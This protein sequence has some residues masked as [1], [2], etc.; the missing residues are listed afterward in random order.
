MRVLTSAALTGLLVFGSAGSLTAQG[1]LRIGFI[2]SGAILEEAPGADEARAEFDR[3]MERWRQELE[4]MSTQID[5]MT[6]AYQQQQTTLLPNVRQARENEIRQMQQ[7][8]QQRVDEMNKEAQDNQNALLGPILD[9]MNDVIE[10]IRT[11]GGYSL[12]FDVASQSIIAADPS[13]DL[14]QEVIRRLKQRADAGGAPD[15]SGTGG[16]GGSDAAGTQ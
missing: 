13:L 14:T 16:T 8:Y 1:N 5:S 9:Q 6:T 7:R 4:T 3:Q 15:S 10:G 11:E 12:I 2:D